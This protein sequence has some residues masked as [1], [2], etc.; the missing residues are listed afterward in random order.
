M[1][2]IIVLDENNQAA[3]NTVVSTEADVPYNYDDCFTLDNNNRRALRVVVSNGQAKT[4]PT[5]SEN[6]YEMI[7][8]YVGHT[9]STY[10]RGYFYDCTRSVA[11]ASTISI[12]QQTGAGVTPSVNKTTF[13]TKIQKSG[14]YDFA[15]DGTNWKLD[16]ETV[17]I[18]DYGISYTES[19]QATAS[20]EG[21]GISSANVVLATFKTQVEATGN[22]VFT[23]DGSAWKLDGET[24]DLSDYGITPVATSASA[25]ISQTAGESLSDL[26]VNA[27]TFASQVSESRDYVFSYDGTDWYLDGVAVDLE[28]Y[29][30]SY[31]GTAEEN[32]A[33]TVSYTEA[34]FYEGDEI[35][36][37]YEKGLEEGEVLRV[38]YVQPVYSY[39]WTQINVQPTA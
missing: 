22:Y 10:T 37:A 39:A 26:T 13:E 17:T 3:V 20:V 24:A 7:V 25:T 15:Y 19:E 38:V 32:D 2:D 8:Q 30:I 23:Y 5:A 31:T 6:T 18:A 35:T 27:S 14:T 21:D 11:T 9:D 36:I 12:T 1:D 4:M 29:G 16:G 34:G 28:D 33:L